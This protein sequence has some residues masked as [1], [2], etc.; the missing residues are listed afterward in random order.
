MLLKR[1]QIDISL[2]D[3]NGETAL[4]SASK[5]TNAT[6]V[7]LLMREQNIL[8]S[9]RRNHKQ[10]ALQCAVSGKQEKSIVTCKTI[11]KSSRY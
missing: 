1:K 2:E 9:E 7:R 6:N 11:A 3:K 5:Y 10:T 8:K 4:I